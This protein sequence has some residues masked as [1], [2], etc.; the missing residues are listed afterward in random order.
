M[1]VSLD[2]LDEIEDDVGTAAVSVPATTAAGAA[3]APPGHKLVNPFLLFQQRNSVGAIFKGDQIKM[4]HNTGAVLRERGG[5]VKGKVEAGERFLANPPEMIETWTKFGDGEVSARLVY[6]TAL[7]EMAPP[8]DELP[9]TD[10]KERGKRKDP[11]ARTVLLPMKDGSGEVCAF[12][13]TGKTAIAEI[14]ELVGMYGS[15]DRE[16]KLPEVEIDARNFE[17]Q[18]GTKI[19]VPVFRLVGWRFWEDG[20]PTPAVQPVAVALAL[21]AKPAAAKT[22]SKARGDLDDEIPF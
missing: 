13:A 12:K 17:S 10:W 15:H 11:W 4:D 21:P 5:D 18:H 3:V 8:R 22:P 7:G 19:Y 16:G 20:Q 14:A 6:R 9:D 2:D 1:K